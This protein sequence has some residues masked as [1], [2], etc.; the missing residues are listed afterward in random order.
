M[1]ATRVYVVHEDGKAIA[2]V[3]ATSQAQAIRHVV[4]EKFEAIPAD[5][6]HLIDLLGKGMMVANAS[7]DGE[8]AEAE[9]RG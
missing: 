6:D 3:R 2:L 8:A 5:Q 4:G 9:K 7:A 1:A